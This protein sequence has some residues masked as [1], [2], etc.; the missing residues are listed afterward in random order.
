MFDDFKRM[1]ADLA[2]EERNKL[3]HDN[4]AR[5]YRIA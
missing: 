3:F 5:F 1:T 4:A 2:A